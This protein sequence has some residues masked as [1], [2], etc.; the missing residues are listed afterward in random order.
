[1]AKAAAPQDPGATLVE[2]ATQSVNETAKSVQESTQAILPQGLQQGQQGVMDLAQIGI[3]SGAVILALV[4][5]WLVLVLLAR[6]TPV[7]KRSGREVD[8]KLLGLVRHASSY[9]LV[10]AGMFIALSALYLPVQPTDWHALAWHAFITLAI[11]ATALLL[12][13][14]VD[15]FITFLA[16][17]TRSKAALLDRQILPLLRDIL[18]AV[19]MVLAVA[20]LVQ[21]WGYNVNTLLAGLGLG[22]LAVAFAAQDTIA[23][24]FGSLVIYT[25][26]PFRIG[27]WVEIGDVE[28]T[29]EEIGIRSTRIRCFDRSLVCVPNKSVSGMNIQNNSAMNKRRIRLTLTVAVSSPL[30]GL[31][32]G[33]TGIRALIATDERISD[34]GVAVNLESI[35]PAG[36]EIMV[37]CYT[38]SVDWHT[39]LF[40][41]EEL[42]L[43]ILRE[44]AHAGITITEQQLAMSPRAAAGTGSGA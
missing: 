41:R 25:D 4:L 19:L 30:A 20:A 27:D 40:V 3:A 26:R 21:T 12:Y 11:G 1:M 6:L 16:G 9:A 18:K 22:G 39:F 23:N 15:V 44:L 38:Q 17:P 5:R 7:I 14:A 32:A 33:L 29:V 37:L 28:G 24:I 34:E 35:S 42:I 13:Y 10:L 2:Q 36:I 8:L 43:G 31:Q